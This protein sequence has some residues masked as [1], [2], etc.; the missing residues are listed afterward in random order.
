MSKPTDEKQ[1]SG[2]YLFNKT[3]DTLT[4]TNNYINQIIDNIQQVENCQFNLVEIVL[5][6]EDEILAVNK[7]HLQHHYVTDIITFPYS[8]KEDKNNIEGTLYCC[9]P[10]IKEQA[11]N[12]DKTVKNE[13]S[14]IIIHGLLHLYGYNDKTE[15]EQKTMTEKEEFYLNKIALR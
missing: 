6:D 8:H 15:D 12:N 10:R 7:E 4:L 9:F 5:V 11:R 2:L 13:L 1:Y 14:R 3:N